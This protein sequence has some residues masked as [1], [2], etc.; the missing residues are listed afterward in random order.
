[1]TLGQYVAHVMHIQS[2]TQ[3]CEME[4][5]HNIVTFSPDYVND[6]VT[7][8]DSGEEKN[9]VMYSLPGSQLRAEC[10]F[11]IFKKFEEFDP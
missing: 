6:S 7:D 1:M 2:D 3:N 11:N 10:K 4:I 9:V 5:L 8:E